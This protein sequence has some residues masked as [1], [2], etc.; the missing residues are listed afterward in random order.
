MDGV[1]GALRAL[2]AASKGARA[3]IALIFGA[4]GWM[5]LSRS[6]SN[7]AA[8]AIASDASEPMRQP[9]LVNRL[10]LNAGIRLTG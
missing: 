8:P 7:R 3:A 2:G 1:I 10:G 5:I 6:K 9:G 4:T